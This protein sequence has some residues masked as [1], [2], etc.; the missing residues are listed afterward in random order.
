MP[1]HGWQS[2]ERGREATELLGTEPIAING[3]APFVSTA[4]ETRRCSMGREPP[5]SKSH[6][7]PNRPLTSSRRLRFW[8]VIHCVSEDTLAEK[9]KC[10]TGYV[11]IANTQLALAALH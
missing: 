3:F 10:K 5:R 9:L 11:P 2:Q 6:P 8:Q 7:C 1:N 4:R